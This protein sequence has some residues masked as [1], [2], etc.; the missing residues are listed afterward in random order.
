MLFFVDESFQTLGGQQVGALGAIAIQAENYNKFCNTIY[1]AK[2][3]LLGASELQH[4]ELKGNTCL[5]KAQFH[6]LEKSGNSPLLDTVDALVSSLVECEATV[7]GLWTSKPELLSLHKVATT[8]Q[9]TVPYIKLLHYFALCPSGPIQISGPPGC[10]LSRPTRSCRGYACRLH[11]LK[12]PLQTQGKRVA[13]LVL[14]ASPPLHT[15]R[16]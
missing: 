4:K 5:T 11:D 15:Q 12:L 9:L 2:R 6:R 10:P 3:D 7:F 13:S 1:R 8:T 16:R 14:V